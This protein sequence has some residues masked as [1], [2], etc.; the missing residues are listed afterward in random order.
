MSLPLA[1]IDDAL[2]LSMAFEQVEVTAGR[3][4]GHRATF[5]YSL[6][7]DRGWDVCAE[8]DGKVLAIRHCRDWCGV[9]RQH[10]WLLAEL[11]A[12]STHEV[13]MCD[14]LAC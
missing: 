9:E 14:C 10:L 4:N 7:P 3:S 6:S 8:L 5:R 12:S 11:D 1:G 13:V 2:C